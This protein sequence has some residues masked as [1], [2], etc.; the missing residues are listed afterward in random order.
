MAAMG[1]LDFYAEVGKEESLS[2]NYFRIVMVEDSK[3]KVIEA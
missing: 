3:E 1:D 2:Y